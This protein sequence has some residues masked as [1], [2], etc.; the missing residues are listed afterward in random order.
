MA[1]TLHLVRHAQGFHNLCIENHQLPDPDLTE[2][3]KQQ[4]ETLRGR[5]PHH[6]RITHLVASPMR[7]TI[8]TCLLSFAPAS[9]AGR[10]VVAVP[11]LQE[12]SLFP[13]DTG[14]EP[15]RLRAEFPAA[16]GKV[17]LGRVAEGWN[18]K[19]EGSPWFPEF[20]RLQA[21]AR[22][23]RQFLRR[24]AREAGEDGHIAVVTH[25]GFLHFLTDDFDGL[26]VNN[27]TGW[28]NTECRS[29]EFVDLN[30]ED[31]NAALQ[32][33]RA[34]SRARRGSATGLTETEHMELKAVVREHL[35]DEFGG[36]K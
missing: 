14:S 18:D 19:S 34:S 16:E 32:E 11:E 7:R 27:G 31:D 4:C 12:V 30:G 2:L 21:R 23:A 33:T 3:G 24:L 15:A 22:K 36:S 6:D 1:P 8:Y 28:S 13:C 9:A 29:Y 10:P 35:K 5:F 20:D 26:D 17:D 25:G